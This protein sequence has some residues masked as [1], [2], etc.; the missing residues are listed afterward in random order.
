MHF[1][2]PSTPFTANII[3]IGRAHTFPYRVVFAVNLKYL[4]ARWLFPKIDKYLAISSSLDG[5]NGIRHQCYSMNIVHCVFVYRLNWNCCIAFRQRMHNYLA[6]TLC[7]TRVRHFRVI[8][9]EIT[10]ALTKS[11]TK[12]AANAKINV[13][14]SPSLSLS[15]LPLDL[16]FL[17]IIVN[18]NCTNSY[19]RPRNQLRLPLLHGLISSLAVS[20]W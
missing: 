14:L 18:C 2:N 11:P 13:S 6:C 12:C 15:P 1:A 19:R 3:H 7:A 10:K 17:L 5:P 20:V 16:P 4:A 9:T 8:E